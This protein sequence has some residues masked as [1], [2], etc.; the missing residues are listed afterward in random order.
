MSILTIH[1]SHVPIGYFTI[2]GNLCPQ[3]GVYLS[4]NGHSRFV[5]WRGRPMPANDGK[6]TGWILESYWI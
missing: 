5:C 2:S 4:S 1:N 6:Q 3:D